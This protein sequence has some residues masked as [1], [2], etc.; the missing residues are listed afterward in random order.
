MHRYAPQ[1]T[2]PRLTRREL[3][4]SFA[5]LCH[6]VDE[7]VRDMQAEAAQLDVEVAELDTLAA[8]AKTL[9]NR[10]SYVSSELRVFADSFLAE[11]T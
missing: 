5:R 6:L 7:S 2:T 9:R 8:A 4:S 3:S 10:A 11:A 1:L